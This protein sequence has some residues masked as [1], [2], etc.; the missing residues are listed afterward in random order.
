MILILV[1]ACFLLMFLWLDLRV[2]AIEK[3]SKDTQFSIPKLLDKIS[4]LRKRL[5]EAEKF[6]NIENFDPDKKDQ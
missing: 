5:E 6:L 4:Q 1:I 2:N 3:T